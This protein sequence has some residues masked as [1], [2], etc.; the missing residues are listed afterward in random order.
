MYT[1]DRASQVLAEGLEPGE[2]VT[3][4]A[5]LKKSKVA[6]PTLFYRDHGEPLREA[7][8]RKQ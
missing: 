4:I 3:Y 6:R 1:I 8:A 7:K 2:R 5:L